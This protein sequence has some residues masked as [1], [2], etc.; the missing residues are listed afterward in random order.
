M[1]TRTASI[2]SI[3][4]VI[5]VVTALG[6][7]ALKLEFDYEFEKFFPLNDPGLA[8]YKKLSSSF[9]NDNDYLLIGIENDHGVFESDFLK[10]IKNVQGHLKNIEGL[11][12]IHI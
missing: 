5:G 7:F 6:W 1:L 4:S 9:G 10:K 2:I 3:I 12:L 11:S 8:D